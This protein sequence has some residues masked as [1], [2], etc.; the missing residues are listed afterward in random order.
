MDRGVTG[1]FWIAI[2]TS[3]LSIVSVPPATALVEKNPFVDCEGGE[4]PTA[5]TGEPQNPANTRSPA[6]IM[7]TATGPKNQSDGIPPPEAAAPPPIA[8]TPTPIRTKESPRLVW[9]RKAPTTTST[10]PITIA[11]IPGAGTFR[12]S[13][14]AINPLPLVLLSTSSGRCTPIGQSDAHF[15][16]APAEDPAEAAGCWLSSDVEEAGEVD[17]RVHSD[18][19]LN[20]C[21]RT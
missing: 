9:K 8:S 10:A 19:M 13:V 3:K 11:T 18:P 1:H 4:P 15:L 14:H 20:P 2:A 16:S 6:T 21:D 7:P 12:H 17:L 5:A